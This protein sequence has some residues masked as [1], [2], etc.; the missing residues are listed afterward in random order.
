MAPEA[1]EGIIDNVGWLLWQLPNDSEA[2]G[3][4][5]GCRSIFDDGCFLL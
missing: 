1:R 4:G 2:I 5:F 3:H